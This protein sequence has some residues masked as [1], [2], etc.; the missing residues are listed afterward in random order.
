M[1]VIHLDAIKQI[2]S[3]HG[4]IIKRKINAAAGTA[5]HDKIIPHRHIESHIRTY[6]VTIMRPILRNDITR[7]QIGV[8]HL[9]IRS[10]GC[11]H[12]GCP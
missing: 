1:I 11:Q 12:I 5:L 2:V 10:S 8:I 3:V 9:G 4:N 7:H 6:P